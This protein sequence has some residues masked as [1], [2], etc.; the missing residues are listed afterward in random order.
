MQ[1]DPYF[2]GYGSLVNTATHVYGRSHPARLSG[3]RRV[4]RHTP[5]RDMAFLTAERCDG[6]AID[7]LIAAVPG[8]D[9]TALDARELGYDRVALLDGISHAAED[10]GEIAVYHIPRDKHGPAEG[11][12]PVL[13]SYLD[14]VVQGYLRV[15]GEEGGRHFFETTAGWDGPILNDR[16]APRYPRAQTLSAKET[17][18]VDRHLRELGVEI[19][20]E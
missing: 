15:F 14:V 6:V 9:W 13:L 10:A 3:W 5:I 4:W 18:L 16:A 19:L 20:D 12:R 2:F 8:A 17:G 1:R 11:H 7:G